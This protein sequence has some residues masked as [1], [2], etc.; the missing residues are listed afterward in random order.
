M[1]SFYG[2]INAKSLL[3]TCS[4]PVLEIFDKNL[5]IRIYTDASLKGIGAV[6]KQVQNDG[7]EIQRSIFFKKIKRC[8]EKKKSNLLRMSSNKRS[9]KILAILAD[10]KKIYNFY[11]LPIEIST[12]RYSCVKV[13]I[14]KKKSLLLKCY[15]K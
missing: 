2:L 9:G 11:R 1:R 14:S 5:P 6:F 7:K 15:T 12:W 8:T 13:Q 4:Q 3:Q 10:W